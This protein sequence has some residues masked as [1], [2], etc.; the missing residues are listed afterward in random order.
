MPQIHRLIALS[1]GVSAAC[2]SQA[3]SDYHGEILASLTGQVTSSRSTAT[4]DAEA[5]AIWLPGDAAFP[6]ADRVDV[7]GDFPATFRLDITE[8][9]A[10]DASLNGLGKLAIG[11]VTVLEAGTT[12]EDF[13]S[14]SDASYFLGLEE[15]YVLVWAASDE[16]GQALAQGS[17]WDGPAPSAGYHITEVLGLSLEED[18]QVESCY[19]QAETEEAT[20]ACLEL[21]FELHRAAHPDIE[22]DDDEDVV[23]DK[24]RLAADDLDTDLSIDLKDSIEE[25]DFPDI[26]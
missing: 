6:T 15:R 16:A 19:E 22:Y 1:L 10:A 5:V 24:L 13:R 23:F 18:Q 11:F 4:P 14:S 3:D 8:P 9:P 25:F 20:A 2:S 26:N 7:E 17:A 12:E 21:S